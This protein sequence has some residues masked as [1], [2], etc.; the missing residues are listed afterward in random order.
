[1]TVYLLTGANA[2]GAHKLCEV[3]VF[4]MGLRT[5]DAIGMGRATLMRWVASVGPEVSVLLMNDASAHLIHLQRQAFL[6][7]VMAACRS[8][9]VSHA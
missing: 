6:R 2:K 8:R 5:Q 1:M 9:A 3:L 4:V 7:S